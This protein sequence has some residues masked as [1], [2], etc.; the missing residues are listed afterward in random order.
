MKLKKFFRNMACG[1]AIGVAMIIPGVSGGT[2]A[3][4][5]GVFDELINA[6][7]NLF[8]DIKNSIKFLIPFALGAVIAVAAVYFPLKYALANAPLPTVLLFT[9]LM[10]G[11]CPQLLKTAREKGFEKMNLLSVILPFLL[12]V[13]L[14]FIPGTGSADLSPEM[15]V[16][17]YLPLFLVAVLAACALVVPGI[18]GSMLLLIF[19]YYA[20]VINTVSGLKD[21]FGHSVL[22]LAVF[23]LGV[24]I[25]FFTIA[26]IMKLLL[27]KFP[28]G[29]RWAIVGFVLGSIPAIFLTFDYAGSPIDAVQIT[30]GV[31]LC[32]A[33]TAATYLM[34]TFEDKKRKRAEKDTE[35]D[36]KN[37]AG[38]DT[39]SDR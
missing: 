4:L 36:T 38:T 1:G 29:T 19:G 16:W 28:K 17:G 26:R 22:V 25:G 5:L 9:G 12:V 2:V 23:A 30:V 18:S 20:P 10:I 7:S 32:L 3:V 6:V 15:N 39:E 33:G 14:C 13:G 24:I 8:S 35:T 37:N 21:N 34:T 27:E 31:I 11:S